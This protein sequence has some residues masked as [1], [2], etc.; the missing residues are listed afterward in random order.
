MAERDPRIVTDAASPL[1]TPMDTP[2]AVRTGRWRKYVLMALVPLLLIGGV[3]WYWVA[4]EHIVTTD[5]AYVQQDKLSVS[6]EVGG[7]I[8]EVRVGENQQVKAGDLLFRLDPAPYRIAIAQANASIAS[9]Q[10][11]VVGLE[12]EFQNSGVDIDSAREDVT[13]FEAE[14]RRQ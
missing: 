14:Y 5:N 12:T 9:A 10:V 1:A 8:V 7:R 13:F 2:P 11:R 6:A 4:N 3:T